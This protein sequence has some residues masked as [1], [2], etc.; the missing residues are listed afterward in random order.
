METLNLKR[1]LKHLYSPSAK[2]FTLVDVPPMNFLM[3]DG[4]GDPNVVPAYGEALEALYAVA[5]T[6]KFAV[7]NALGIDYPVMASEGLWWSADMDS[8]SLGRRDEWLWTMMIM[9]PDLIT[10]SM[11]ADAVKRT[12]D[13]KQLPALARLR[14]EG[15]HE[16][17]AAQIMHIGPFSTEAPTIARMHQEFIPANG[18]EPNGKHHEIYLSD[19][20]RTMPEKLKTVLRQ[21]VRRQ[22]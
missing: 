13:K 18:C 11:V 22:G 12:Q 10:A 15:Y 7:K 6:L 5:Y 1:D 17:L 14:F 20:R 19:P 16:G 3:I 4:K 9:Q 21:P 2:A 8:F